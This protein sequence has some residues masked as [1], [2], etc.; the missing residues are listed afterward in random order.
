MALVSF[1]MASSMLNF[2][3][4]KNQRIISSSSL[5]L[6]PVGSPGCSFSNLS[7]TSKTSLEVEAAPG[8]AL[9]Q[10]TALLE[11]HRGSGGARTMERKEHAAAIAPFPFRPPFV[12]LI[13]GR[14]DVLRWI[15]RLEPALRLPDKVDG[16]SKRCGE[17]SRYL[18][19][20]RLRAGT[21]RRRR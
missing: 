14:R 4:F 15:G 8:V 2:L 6:L 16:A 5:P 13:C 10:R 17:Q 9:Q 1:E 18:P 19:R 21:C 20:R 12:S 7:L 11:G 3:S